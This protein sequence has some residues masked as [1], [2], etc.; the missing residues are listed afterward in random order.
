MSLCSLLSGCGSVQQHTQARVTRFG[1]LQVPLLASL[2]PAQLSQLCTKMGSE[3]H[4]AGA[5]IFQ[6][7]SHSASCLHIAVKCIPRC[8]QCVCCAAQQ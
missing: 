6:S 8:L 5:A 7:V 4:D 1:M 3:H 2:Q